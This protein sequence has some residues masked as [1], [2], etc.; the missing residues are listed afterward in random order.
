MLKTTNPSEYIEGRLKKTMEQ[1]L[2]PRG[3]E[4]F[5]DLFHLVQLQEKE[6]PQTKLVVAELITKFLEQVEAKPEEPCSPLVKKQKTNANAGSKSADTGNDYK[7]KLLVL[8]IFV[9]ILKESLDDLCR[10]LFDEMHVY[11]EQGNAIAEY[12]GG[13]VYQLLI[14]PDEDC[15][16]RYLNAA[17]DLFDSAADHGSAHALYTLGCMSL[18]KDQAIDDDM[19]GAADQIKKAADLGFVPA[20]FRLGHL[21]YMGGSDAEE[22]PEKR[23]FNLKKAVELFTLAAEQGNNE[24]RYKLAVMFI[25]GV[26][27]VKKDVKKGLELLTLAAT[28][29]NADAQNLL[30]S[31]HFYED[32]V[33]QIGPRN[34]REGLKWFRLSAAQG[35]DLAEEN[36]SDIINNRSRF[37]SSSDSDAVYDSASSSGDDNNDNDNDND[38]DDIMQPSLSGN[39]VNHFG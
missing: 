9:A 37:F 19:V 11:A 15:E 8:K 22:T 21:Y 20:I 13:V 29:G 18:Y 1:I 10:V 7:V 17:I 23:E 24:A 3:L 36:L 26:C 32:N 38:N 6:S 34:C 27:G 5:I 30:G 25:N 14:A 12:T 39:P 4:N 28:E 33:P 16:K 35:N 31:L 2:S